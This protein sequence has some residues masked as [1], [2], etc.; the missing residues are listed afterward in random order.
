MNTECPKCRLAMEEGFIRD[1]D[2]GTGHSAPSNWVEGAP[3]KSIWSGVKTAG[4]KQARIE[5]SPLSR[6]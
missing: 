6:R 1:Q 4:K 5:E 2:Y 3:V